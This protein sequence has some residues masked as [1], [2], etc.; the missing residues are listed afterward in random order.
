MRC[1]RRSGRGSSRRVEGP[2]EDCSVT[3][4]RVDERLTHKKEDPRCERNGTEY[5][6][7]SLADGQ[8]NLVLTHTGWRDEREK[9]KER[10]CCSRKQRL[11]CQRRKDGKKGRKTRSQISAQ[12]PGPALLGAGMPLAPDWFRV[13]GP[14]MA[15]S[16]PRAT[17]LAGA[18]LPR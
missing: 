1:L 11:V 7:Q 10:H 9:K 8:R 13:T 15:L 5:T 2:W 16:N 4:R 14:N 18:C 17:S 12:P 3:Q 6:R